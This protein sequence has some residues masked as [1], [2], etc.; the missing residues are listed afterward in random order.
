[1]DQTAGERIASEVPMSDKVCPYW[2]GYLLVN[3]LRRLVHNPEKIL[4]PY[5]RSGMTVLDVGCAMGFFTIP[6]ARMVGPRGTVLC[7]DLQE[8]MLQALL[9]RARKAGVLDRL[10]TRQCDGGSLGLQDFRRRV[11]FALAFAVVHEVPDAARFFSELSEVL[12]VGAMCLVAEP[13]G[14]VSGKD[15]ET[16]LAI[17]RE[18]GFENLAR[19][20]VMRSHTA[21]LQQEARQ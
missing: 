4:E 6:M 3:P 11:D 10:V 19:L 7:V 17:A 9:R 12:K 21:L 16:T 20:Q 14:H 5:V 15:F 1:M 8:K 13:K 18:A 2:V